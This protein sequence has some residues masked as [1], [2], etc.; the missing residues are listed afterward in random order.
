MSTA[1]F[2]IQ[3]PFEELKWAFCDLLSAI[4]NLYA[5]IIIMTEFILLN[6]VHSSIGIPAPP[7]I[8]T[9]LQVKQ[10][11]IFPTAFLSPGM[12]EHGR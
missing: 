7:V 5:E 8:E 10:I 6:R 2:S 1:C 12:S 9:E 11:P 4:F 3:R